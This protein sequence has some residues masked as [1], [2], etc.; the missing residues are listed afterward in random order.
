MLSAMLC[1]TVKFCLLKT[2]LHITH[3]M[4]ITYHQCIIAFVSEECG[5]IKC[6]SNAH[7]VVKNRCACN[8]GYSG[9]PRKLCEREYIPEIP[10]MI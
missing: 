1:D 3:L 4:L 8:E 5:F 6:V 10:D 9:D 2:L 7:C